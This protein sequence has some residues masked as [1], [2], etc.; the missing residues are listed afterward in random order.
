MPA[1]A[2]YFEADLRR[3][4]ILT[5]KNANYLTADHNRAF[6]L[7]GWFFIVGVCIVSTLH[8]Q[9]YSSSNPGSFGIDGDVYSDTVLNGSFPPAGS[10]D[11]FYK[12]GGAG[13][14]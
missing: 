6:G 4:K 11:W 5:M 2:L 3:T 8:A 13:I 7:K 12:T 9:T 1:R 10:H 14:G